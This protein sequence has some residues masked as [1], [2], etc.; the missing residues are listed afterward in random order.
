MFKSKTL[1]RNYL[2]FAGNIGEA[3]GLDIL[4]VDA[5]MHLKDEEIKVKF[6]IIGDG[7]TQKDLMKNFQGKLVS[8]YFYFINRQPAALIPYYLAK[9]DFA[10]VTLKK[11]DIFNQTIPAKIQ[12]LMACGKPLVTMENIKK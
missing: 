8:D 6:I 12:S 4:V 11:N 1:K 9:F 5:A 10:L 2:F 7:R 3:K